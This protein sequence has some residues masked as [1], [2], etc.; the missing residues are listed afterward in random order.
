MR[1][2][3]GDALRQGEKKCPRSPAAKG[4]RESRA[5]G[6]GLPEVGHSE[7]RLHAETKREKAGGR[8]GEVQNRGT[9]TRSPGKRLTLVTQ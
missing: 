5:A 3:S 7:A 4:S 8:G 1:R 9:K 2:I 6:Q